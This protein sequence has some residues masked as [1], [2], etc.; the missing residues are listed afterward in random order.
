MWLL[1][2]SFPGSPAT[3]AAIG[4]ALL[5]A[6]PDQPVLRI[7]RPAPTVGFGRLDAHLPGFGAAALASRANGFVPVLR[8]PGGRAAAYHLGSLLVE[9]VAAE[10]DP[11][12]GMRDRFGSF[13]TTLADALRTL[14]VD[15]RVGAVDGEYCPGEFSVNAGGRVKLAGVAQRIKRRSWMVGAELV[16]EDGTPVRQ[17]LTDVYSA[18]EL[19][20]DPATAAAVEDVAPGITVDDVERAVVEAFAPSGLLPLTDELRAAAEACAPRH[21]VR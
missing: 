6:P 18:L 12:A 1:R 17:V 19:D 3:D 4:E 5:D 2:A 8:T 10:G 11:I 13:S 21:V 15:A 16:V 20:F 14:G 9:L 7:A